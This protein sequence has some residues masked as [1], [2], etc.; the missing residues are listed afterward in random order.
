MF[1]RTNA[2]GA[3]RG[4]GQYILWRGHNLPG[5]ALGQVT[6]NGTQ[7]RSSIMQGIYEASAQTNRVVALYADSALSFDLS[8]TATFAD[9]A[10]RVD[11]LGEQH[12]GTPTA[13]YMNFSMSFEP[14]T[15][16]VGS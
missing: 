7:F 14:V 1:K 2:S 11:R 5:L 8:K 12:I 10:D 13:I 4:A 16:R 6:P 15:Q 3:F 9:L